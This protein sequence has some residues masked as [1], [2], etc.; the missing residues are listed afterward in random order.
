MLSTGLALSNS[1]IP[2]DLT[3]RALVRIQKIF[4]RAR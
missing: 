3:P 4:A 2:P 1:G